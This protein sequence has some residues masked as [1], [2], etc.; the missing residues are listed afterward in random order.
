MNIN[1]Y[2][3]DFYLENKIDI[4]NVLIE[5]I[6]KDNSVLEKLNLENNNIEKELDNNI[7]EEE[8]NQNK[9]IKKPLLKF[10]NNAEN[11]HIEFEDLNVNI[12]ESIK[13][14]IT[15]ISEIKS[16]S[17][18]ESESEG[19]CEVE[20]EIK[21]DNNNNKTK[22]ETTYLS[23]DEEIKNI[24]KEQDFIKNKGKNNNNIL[25]IIK[26]KK[27]E[28]YEYFD[29]KKYISMYKD[30]S[31]LKSKKDAWDHWINNGKNEN[32]KKCFLQSDKNLITYKNF[33]WVTYLCN[34][35]DL[36]NI[37]TKKKAWE[38]WVKYGKNENR[39]LQ[40]II[41]VDKYRNKLKK[42]N[43]EEKYDS[44][45][46][47]LYINL[48]E[49]LKV[50]NKKQDAWDHWI[51]FGK[52][53][54]RPTN[55]INTS[56]TH[57]GRL[58]NLFFINMATH[59]LALKFNLNFK[60]KYYN[61]FKELGIDFYIGKK[62]Y[63]N[64]ITLTDKNFFDYIKNDIPFSNIIINNDIWCQTKEFSIFLKNYFI[65]DKN[66]IQ[67]IIK[68]NR[69]I[70]R[71]KKNNDVFI[72]VRLGDVTDRQENIY[73]YYNSVLKNLFF[74]KGFISSDSIDHEICKKLIKKY[75]LKV[76]NKNETKTIMFA[77]TCNNLVLSGGTFSWLI[78]FLAFFSKNIYYPKI[79][80][81]WYG[82]IFVYPDWKKIDLTKKI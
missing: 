18:S 69:Y 46:W 52:N 72:H 15:N 43:E 76:I 19:Q 32:R 26:N 64:Y 60:Y 75:D 79:E 24:I 6:T 9:K 16:E 2:Q 33:D 28:E 10:L 54:E 73:N 56:N 13:S 38:H 78:G 7:Q 37:N 82:D 50:F 44:F 74:D 3:E 40:K 22:K 47:L 57:N 68:N 8:V 17:E 70:T 48:N 23:V 53:E 55:Y 63:N 14:N 65:K 29:W 1:E 27:V 4:S 61:T 62:T 39:T 71:Y 12:I 36:N 77:S 5:N 31:Y 80:N 58:G 21:I 34:Y 30:L 49:D 66:L 59:F 51:K 42:I 35:S 25:N 11:I 45:D 81:L 20:S 67:N 41:N